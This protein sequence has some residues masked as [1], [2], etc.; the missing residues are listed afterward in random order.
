MRHRILK[1]HFKLFAPEYCES[2]G[3]CCKG[4]FRMRLRRWCSSLVYRPLTSSFPL[5]S[6]VALHVDGTMASG[7][8]VV[9]ATFS[10]LNIAIKM[11]LSRCQT[12]ERSSPNHDEFKMTSISCRLSTH[13]R[14]I[15][16]P[17]RLWSRPNTLGPRSR[18]R[19]ILSSVIPTNP[20]R[21]W[22]NSPLARWLSFIIIY[23]L[24]FR[25]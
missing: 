15:S 17:T 8:S 7:V 18:S 13:T 22:K 12:D 10:S 9:H 1:K 3:I 23:L 16:A 4:D 14:K 5:P 21:S 6:S 2:S 20:R 19:T 24:Y 25:S 11:H